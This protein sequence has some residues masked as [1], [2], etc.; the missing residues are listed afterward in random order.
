MTSEEKTKVKNDQ[1]L[2]HLLEDV[3][4][5]SPSTSSEDS[6]KIRNDSGCSY[7]FSDDLQ[8]KPSSKVGSSGHSTDSGQGS[9]ADIHDELGIIY[10]YHFKIPNHLCG[11][12]A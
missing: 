2:C 10:A 4:V 12:K 5:T 6:R 9:S 8:K 1:D 11:K 7:E 3:R